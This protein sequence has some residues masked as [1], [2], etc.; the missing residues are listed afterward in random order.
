ME[1]LFKEIKKFLI[2]AIGNN[3]AFWLQLILIL[4]L[5]EF[6]N[7]FYIWSYLISLILVTILLSF[8]NEYITFKRRKKNLI[9]NLIKFTAV[10]IGIYIPNIIIVYFVTNFLNSLIIFEYNYFLAIIV[11][12]I[13]YAIGYY[14]L[15]RKWIFKTPPPISSG[16]LKSVLEKI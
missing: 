8:Y 12:S 11:V 10:T 13:P 9:K 14:F 6:L 1:S 15:C 16:K 4:L 5:T 7:L 2:F 3:L